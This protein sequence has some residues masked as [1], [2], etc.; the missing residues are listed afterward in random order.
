VR[1][2]DLLTAVRRAL[3]LEDPAPAGRIERT[4]ARTAAAPI[5]VLLAEDHPVNQHLV[6]RLLGRRGHT[7]VVAPD[8]RAAVAAFETGS[9]DLVLM[10]VQMPVMDGLT[11][12][13]AIR[14]LEAERGGHVPIVAMTA[15]AMTGDRE[16]CL[17]AGMDEYVSKPI[18]PMALIALVNRIAAASPAAAARMRAR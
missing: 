17:E 3:K 10:D 6:Q 11:A 2:S 16:R 13:A 5:R 4:A 8:G 9:F 12:T 7:V 1:T 18:E 14:S 15:H